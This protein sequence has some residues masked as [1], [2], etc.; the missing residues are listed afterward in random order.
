MSNQE[1]SVIIREDGN[2]ICLDHPEC[3][4]F[5]EMG[6]VKTRRAS[7]VEPYTWYYRWAFHFLRWLFGENGRVGDWTRYGSPW[8]DH[9]WRV[10]LTPVGGP[11]L[12]GASHPRERALKREVEWL[13]ENLT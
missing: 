4:C 8:K 6:P 13:N 9:L 12:P 11:I 5:R 2:V 3:E 10:N 1:V 7:H